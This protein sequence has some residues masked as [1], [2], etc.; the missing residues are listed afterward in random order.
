MRCGDAFEQLD[1]AIAAASPAERAGLVVALSARL[2]TLGA[3]GLAQHDAPPTESPDRNLDVPEIARRMNVSKVWVYRN[4]KG[5]P[6]AVRVGRRLL[7]SERGLS[8]YLA[9]KTGRV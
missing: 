4:L 8:R 7:G 2:A 3:A 9:K 6:F 1:A 5:L